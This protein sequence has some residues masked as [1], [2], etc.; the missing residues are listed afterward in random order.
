M[1]DRTDALA[2]LMG[3]IFRLEQ[4]GQRVPCV[5]PTI[6]H[7]WLADDDEMQDA[8]VTACLTCPALDTCRGYVALHPE[9][10]GVWAAIYPPRRGRNRTGASR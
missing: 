3:S 8:A 10:G 1:T 4:D 6:G 2:V 9:D 5:R 7:W